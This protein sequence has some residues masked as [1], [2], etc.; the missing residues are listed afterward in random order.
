MRSGLA[1]AL[2]V[3][4]AVTMAGQAGAAAENPDTAKAAATPA[5]ATAPAAPGTDQGTTNLR[6]EQD[7]LDRDL[8]H[9]DETTRLRIEAFEKQISA[10]DLRIG[11]LSLS[12]ERDS[13]TITLLAIFI[14][15]ATAAFGFAAFF[16][17]RTQALKAVK[18]WLDDHGPEVLERL[19]DETQQKM[20]QRLGKLESELEGVLAKATRQSKELENLVERAGGQIAERKEEEVSPGDKKEIAQAA[21][22]AKAKP[23]SEKMFPDWFSIGIDAYLNDNYLRAA[24]AFDHAARSK[25][26]TSAQKARAL[27]NKGAALGMAEEL[28]GAIVAYD[29]VVQRFGD[30]EEPALREQV[31]MALFNKGVALGNAEKLEDAIA[32]SDEVV[33]RFGDAEEPALREQVAM[34]LNGRAFSRLCLAKRSWRGPDGE[35]EARALLSQAL[36]DADAALNISPDDAIRLGNK[37]Y[38]LYLLGRTEEAEPVLRRALELGGEKVRDAELEDADIH[39]LPQDEAFKELIHRLWTE[40]SGNN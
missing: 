9:L 34:A 33:R 24:E 40:V 3:I 18:T 36:T 11:D 10:Q 5:P 38:T 4:L 13:N 26:A 12:A 16:S 31:A 15:V 30:A 39:P 6:R 25:E 37:G 28:E 17:A 21:K 29:E 8:K 22:D 27:V 23:D 14:A 1:C 19:K 20:N 32:A 35:E 2:L 7:L